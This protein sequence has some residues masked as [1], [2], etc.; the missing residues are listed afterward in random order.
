M[1]KTF[2]TYI[3][4]NKLDDDGVGIT[5]NYPTYKHF[6]KNVGQKSPISSIIQIIIFQNNLGNIH[7][8]KHTLFKTYID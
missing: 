6:W 1:L 2:I 7:C 3:V 5:E 4:K 8:L